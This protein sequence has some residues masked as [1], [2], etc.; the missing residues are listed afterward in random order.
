M[1]RAVA[2]LSAELALSALGEEHA[3]ALAEAE[4]LVTHLTS[5]I[6]VDEAGAVQ[7][8]VPAMRK[9]RLPTPRSSMRRMAS[10]GIEYM[11][12]HESLKHR[13]NLGSS[14]E[15]LVPDSWEALRP[16]FQGSLSGEVGIDLSGIGFEI[17]WDSAPKSLLGGDLR[18]LD[19]AV[20]RMIERAAKLPEVIAV[21]KKLKL[22]PVALVVG[23]IA[24]EMSAS[25]RSAA[26][27]VRAIISPRQSPEI[28]N[29]ASRLGLGQ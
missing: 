29:V 11:P 5:L 3:A 16:S 24:I 7:K 17:D 10:V 21:A 1:T 22:S 28:E 19:P 18:G 14:K 15:M 13:K 2:A 12:A 27:I 23:L 9:I 8:G 26:R 25:N 4:G 6:L 20:V